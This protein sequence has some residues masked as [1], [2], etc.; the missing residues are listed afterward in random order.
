MP[1]A[2]A[3]L[4]ERPLPLIT[5]P[6]LRLF[7][8]A[9][10][11]FQRPQT[12]LI[13]RFVPVRRLATADQAA[14]LSL[15]GACLNDALNAAAGD[16]ALAG[17][18]TSTET[19]LEGVRLSVTGFGDAPARYATYLAGQLRTFTLTPQRFEA[20]KE[21]LLRG[22]RS[23]EET[24]AYL[25]ARD[26]RDALAREFQFLPNELV[27]RTTSATWADVQAFAKT[28][29]ATGV[30]EGLVHGH[31]S[32]DAAVAATRTV[33]ASI[34]AKP[35]PEAELLRRRH[36]ELAP[37]EDLLDTGLVAGV[38]A[39]FVRDYLL[40]D[41]S[42]STRAAAVVLANYFSR[43]FFTELRTKQQLGYIVGSSAS[44][45]LRQRFFTFVIQ[46]SGYAP[47]ER[48]RRAE[49]FLATLPV[50]F[51]AIPAA[52]WQTLV[53]GARSTLEEKPK[54]ISEKAAQFF[55]S[56]YLYDGEWDRR[57]ATLAALDA[58]TK[59]QALALLT[60]ALAPET[61][62]TR[63]VRLHSAKLTPAAPPT[64][65]FTNR[66]AWKATRKFN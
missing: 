25:L 27:A 11:E 58:L 34:G 23:Y 7:Y 42:P 1:G 15:Y 2:T 19:S 41:D 50:G 60:S 17:L 57:Q 33:A 5:E 39:A 52:E 14:L 30:I 12:T 56:A 64:P 55:S 61:A 63:T 26:R 31:L 47:D 20:V 21:T 38:N 37:R 13:Y 3:L 36:V 8:A 28:F 6:G 59:E 49:A 62:R 65:T 29:F 51:A 22:L 9:D 45:S 18:E 43:L 53:A 32:P 35:A 44:A 4:P 66:S 10:T 48:Q 46:S 16:A 54:S 24:E 40:P